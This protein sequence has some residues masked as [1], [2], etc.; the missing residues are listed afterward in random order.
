[1]G[2]D[3]DEED[4]GWALRGEQSLG[5]RDRLRLGGSYVSMVEPVEDWDITNLEASLATFILHKDYRDYY[6]RK[7][8]SAFARLRFPYL[9]VEVRAEYFDERHE[10]AMIR[11]PWSL[12]KNNDP[13]REQPLVAEGELRFLEGSL[14]VDTRNHRSDPTDGWF[15]QVSARRG[16]GGEIS[17]P[18]HRSSPEE[19]AALIPAQRL[20]TD[21]LAGFLD[22]RSYNRV[23]PGSSLNLRGLLAGSLTDVPLPPQYQ[24]ALGG[25]GS[26]PGYPLFFADCGARGEL[27]GYDVLSNG[28]AVRNRVFPG[29]GCDRI[30]LFQAEFRGSLF[31][32][33]SFG[34]WSEGDE[35]PWGG[36]WNWYPSIELS[37]NW[38]AFF[39]LGRGYT[40]D[41]LGD[42]D[43]LM[44][45]GVGLFLGDLGFYYAFPL[46]EDE[47]GD[48]DGR[49]FVRLSRRF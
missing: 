17:L 40:V 38:A 11:A 33:W 44:D 45:V 29:Y 7:G 48:R 20:D 8:W 25:E 42:T 41:G 5:G 36:D 49:F 23:G 2:M 34:D 24:H 3:L 18:E 21:F 39:N 37:P 27:R 47:Q 31:M 4:F 43:T 15:I 35:D 22:L 46:N 6:Q 10:F 26:L 28:V 30:A 14:S 12:T 19:Q 16:L 32:D 1:M 9:P 13:W